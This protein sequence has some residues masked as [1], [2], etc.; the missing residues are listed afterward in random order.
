M[1]KRLIR[2][3]IAL[4]VLVL[5]GW[6]VAHLLEPK[7]VEVQVIE[8]ERGRVEETV[9]NSRAGTVK[10]RRRTELSPEL[11]GRAIEIPFREG[12]RVPAGAVLLR[13]DASMQEARVVLAEREVAAAEARRTQACLSADRAERELQRFGRLAEEKIVSEDMRDQVENSRL[14]SQAACEAASS[15]V[16]QAAATL[17]LAR[18]E[19]SM[20]TL[21]APF[22]GI[23]AD[24]SIELGEYTTPSPPGLPIPPVIDLLDPE[25]IYISAPMDEVDAARLHAGQPVRV[26]VDSHRGQTFEGTVRRVSDFVLDVEAQNRTV[27]IDVELA[28]KQLAETLRPGTSSD[29]EVILEVHE[30]VTRLPT[31]TLIEGSKV[32][33]VENGILAERP[34]ETG[35]RNWNFTEILSGVDEGDLVVSEIDRAEIEAGAPALVIRSDQ[36]GPS[37]GGGR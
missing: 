20:M 3:S 30:D 5:I 31:S 33:V 26:T 34:I 29:V 12:D 13:L 2:W 1:S 19:L 10:A 9:T 24:L 28:D 6:G 11:G 22:S 37:A 35:L 4:G 23:L 32:L 14:T 15:T 8:V 27:E 7:P 36:E 16:E 18:V 17:Q 25:S 21:R